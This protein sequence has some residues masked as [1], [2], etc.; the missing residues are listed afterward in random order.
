MS[1][2]CIALNLHAITF[3]LQVKYCNQLPVPV[4]AQPLLYTST[5]LHGAQR[6]L[7]NMTCR[8]LFMLQHASSRDAHLCDSKA[9]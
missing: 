9:N 4:P 3:V 5:A 1:A 7:S 8:Q 6:R 2:S